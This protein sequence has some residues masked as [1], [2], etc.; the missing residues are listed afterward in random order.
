MGPQHTHT[1]CAPWFRQAQMSPHGELPGSAL[2]GTT[3]GP[4]QGGR[5]DCGHVSHFLS[6]SVPHTHPRAHTHARRCAHAFA[7][8]STH[9]H[10]TPH[11]GRQT[12][13]L[14]AKASRTLTRDTPSLSPLSRGG[15][16][17]GPA[18]LG[19]T[20]HENC[21][22]GVRVGAAGQ[23]LLQEAHKYLDSVSC[24]EVH[25]LSKPFSQD[26]SIKT[27]LWTSSRD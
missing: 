18:R 21:L 8:A 9:V 14:H 4:K 20:P 15:G 23:L 27:G 22:H 6:S 5:L 3:S 7:H 13:E 11:A 10:R 26:V 24:Q 1:V 19:V 16:V 12:H 2:P 25:T 17:A